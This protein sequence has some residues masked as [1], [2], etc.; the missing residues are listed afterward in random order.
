MSHG[1]PLDHSCPSDVASIYQASSLYFFLIILSLCGC[2]RI[3]LNPSL[4]IDFS[5]IL[6]SL[7]LM[8]AA[9]Y[10][11]ALPSVKICLEPTEC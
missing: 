11:F 4:G 1:T 3:P 8:A 5:L 2:V 10:S 7:F 9:V 6:P